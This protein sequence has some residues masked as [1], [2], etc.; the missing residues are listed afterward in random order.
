M[1]KILNKQ[2]DFELWRKKEIVKAIDDL[3]K[4]TQKMNE[5]KRKKMFGIT[6]KAINPQI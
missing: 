5:C 1:E 4:T 6:F 3:N 2:C